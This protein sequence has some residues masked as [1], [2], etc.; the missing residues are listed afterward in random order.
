[1]KANPRFL[2][3]TAALLIAGAFTLARQRTPAPAPQ[4]QPAT[5]TVFAA[6]SLREAFTQIGLSFQQRSGARVLFNFAGSQQLAE[7]IALAAPA[8]VFASA[9]QHQLDA[10]IS[11]GRI[12]S[13]TARVFA[14]N[15]LVVITP[16]ANPAGINTLQDLSRPGLKLVVAARAV[17]AGQYAH[18]FFEKASAQPA[19]GRTYEQRVLANVVSYEQDVRG[20]FGKVALGEADAGIVYTS[21]VT[22]SNLGS[23]GRIDIPDV[24]NTLASYPIAPVQDS[25]NLPTA[26]AFV[27]YVLSP[28]GQT[29]LARYGF[30]VTDGGAPP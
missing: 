24:L 9:H 7:Q 27:A 17:P 14:R 21:D 29:T 11:A 8:D 22:A 25:P 26:Q 6:A 12:V 16:K 10:A 13:G 4:A 5:I 23:V 19:F 18:D 3:T 15:R 20:V 1:L 28:E 30:V 2:L